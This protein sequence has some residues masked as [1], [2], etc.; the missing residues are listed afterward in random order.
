MRGPFNTTC[1]IICGPGSATPGVLRGTFPCRYVAADGIFLVGAHSPGRVG[2]I[3]VAGILPRGPWTAPGIGM[4]VS[5]ADLVAVPSGVA[6]QYYVLYTDE[7][8]WRGQPLYYR[9]NLVLLPHPH[10]D[11]IQQEDFTYILQED[12][13]FIIVE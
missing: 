4:D 7:V 6:P 10:I 5:V 8:F 11:A 3:T 12:D 13:D 9:A 1:D 2:W